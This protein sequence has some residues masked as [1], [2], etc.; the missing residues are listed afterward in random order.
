M[1]QPIALVVLLP[2]FSKAFVVTKR[3]HD[4]DNI[5]M[6]MDPYEE[7]YQKYIM[8]NQVASSSDNLS[9]DQGQSLQNHDDF[10]FTSP[11]ICSNSFDATS[12]LRLDDDVEEQEQE[13]EIDLTDLEESFLKMLSNEVE[14]KKMLGENPYAITDI[15]ISTLIQRTLDNLEDGTQKGNGKFKGI[16]RLKRKAQ[17]REDRKTVVVLGSGWAAHSFV[18]LASTYDLRI[19]VVSPVNH[20][21]C[22]VYPSIIEYFSMSIFLTL[23]LIFQCPWAGLYSHACQCCCGNCRV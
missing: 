19:V 7:Q 5:V 14:Y 20:F 13:E 4:F 16:S 8:E 22:T 3:Y 17:P 10:F 15:N 18:K 1:R 2:Y 21:V 11:E 9:P 23:M 6:R 12:F